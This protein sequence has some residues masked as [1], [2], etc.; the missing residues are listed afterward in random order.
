MGYSPYYQAIPVESELFRRLQVDRKLECVL[1]H[2]YPR[3]ARPLD[4]LQDGQEELEEDVDFLAERSKLFRSREEVEQTLADLIHLVDRACLDAYPGLMGR[5]VFIEKTL[6]Q[7]EDRL[8]ER[9]EPDR[10]AQ[11]VKPGDWLFSCDSQFSPYKPGGFGGFGIVSPA[12]VRT[13]SAILENVEPGSIFD[14]EAEDYLIEDLQSLKTLYREAAE[15]GEAIL[16]D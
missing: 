8:K 12:R 1:F 5:V 14:S 3:G 9:V 15:L 11:A 10:L 13:V 4:L 7:I 6:D 2:L 16:V